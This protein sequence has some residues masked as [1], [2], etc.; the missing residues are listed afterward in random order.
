MVFCSFTTYTCIYFSCTVD[1]SAQTTIKIRAITCW[2]LLI[3][4]PLL[5]TFDHVSGVT[6][7]EG[8]VGAESPVDWV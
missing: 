6:R 7:R 3:F 5:E 1:N 4:L 2:D 8:G